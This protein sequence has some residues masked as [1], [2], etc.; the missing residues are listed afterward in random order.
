MEQEIGIALFLLPSKTEAWRRFSQIL[1]GSRQNEFS[2]WCHRCGIMGINRWLCEESNSAFVIVH[3]KIADNTQI[4][5]L[6]RTDTSKFQQW[7][8]YQILEL[9]GIDLSHFTQTI[10]H[11]QTIKEV[12]ML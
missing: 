6:L 9:H 7:L 10:P 12:G 11:L 5:Q 3:L 1:S 8:F 4:W 2:A